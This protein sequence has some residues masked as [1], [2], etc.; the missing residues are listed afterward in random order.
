MSQALYPLRLSGRPVA[1]VWGEQDTT[2][3]IGRDIVTDQPIGEIWTAG[4]W[5]GGDEVLD[6]PLAGQTV[7]ALLDR[8]GEDE[9]LG[10]AR[11]TAAGRF[12]LLVKWIGSA[13]DLSI[14]VHP[15]AEASARIGEGAEPKTE[16]W[17]VL[18]AEPGAEI[19]FGL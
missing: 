5:E 3:L 18:G 7:A 2:E 9:I 4:D 14:Q 6:G 13:K 17:Y 10:A 11:R 1:R 12:P 15:D 16:C 8:V 19:I